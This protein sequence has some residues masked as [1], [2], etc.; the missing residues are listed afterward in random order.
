MHEH[1]PAYDNDQDCRTGETCGFDYTHSNYP[2]DR[3]ARGPRN[4]RKKWCLSIVGT[5]CVRDTTCFNLGKD[6]EC[7]SWT[8][9]DERKNEPKVCCYA[10][11][12]ICD[13]YTKKGEECSDHKNCGDDNYCNLYDCMKP[14]HKCLGKEKKNKSCRNDEQCKS[15][16]CS[17]QRCV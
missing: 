10:T 15:H 4:P 13:Y 1:Q 9:R 11:R 17:R 6:L 8:V 7:A 2:Y 16:L 3:H 14:L 5:E 12:D